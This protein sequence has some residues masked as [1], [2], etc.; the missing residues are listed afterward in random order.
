MIPE[1]GEGFVRLSPLKLLLDP[2]KAVG[3]VRRARGHRAG[4]DQPERHEVLADHLPARRAGPAR[5]G[6]AAV[7]DHP[8]PP[9][10]H[11]DP[12]AQRHPQQED[13]DRA[14]GPRAQ[15]RPR[16]VPAPPHP[17]PAEGADRHGGRRRPHHARRPRRRRRPGTA[18]DAADAPRRRGAAGR[19]GDVGRP[20]GPSP[21][22][23]DRLAQPEGSGPTGL[24]P[25][26]L[27]APAVPLARID[28]SWLRFAPF[29]LG[30][31]VLLFGG[32][33]V[34][35]Q[36]AD[37]LPIWNEETATSAWQWL[38]QFAVAA[39][40]LVLSVS[41][42]ALWLVV[43]V[44]GYVLQWWGFRL[45]R[46]HGSL[47]LTSGLVTTRSITRGGGEGPRR[48]DDRAGAHAARR[49][50][51]AL[52]AGHR[53]GGRRHAGAAAVPA[54]GRRRGRRG[55]PR[56]SRP[57]DRSARGARPEG[58]A[59]RVVPPAPQRA[60]RHRAARGRLVVVRPDLVVAR[61]HRRRTAR[62]RRCGG[63]GVVPPPRARPRR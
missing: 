57:A 20:D 32:L 35:S 47:H 21:D 26:P 37:D 53:R 41:A 59:P 40:A 10:R 6:R 33:G 24:A 7:A 51:R 54:R 30:R 43:S 18:Y 34:L 62:P 27:P 15:R 58:P 48:R 22:Q 55:R 38:T 56:A 3:A 61:R 23:P 13:L 29:S 31:L 45:V 4:R 25:A 16:G 52:H 49:R 44:A 8:L 19:A 36:F 11:P 39:I 12:G 14:A 17:R 60:R 46:E 9:D 63:R 42:L 1:P 50:R 5:P 28:W 2:V